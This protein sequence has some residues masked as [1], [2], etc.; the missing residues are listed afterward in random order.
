MQ[1]RLATPDDLEWAAHLMASNEPWITLRRDLEGARKYLSRAGELFIPFDGETRL[2]FLVLH[3]R[4]LAGSPYIASLAVDAPARGR[5]VGAELLRIAEARHPEARHI[6]LLV[7]S[8]NPRARQLYERHG[9]R[10]V[11]ELPDYVVAGHS[12]LIMHKRLR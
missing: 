10:Q 12:E 3:E 2:G 5:G 1:I 6:F 11:G 9:Y 7:S 4:G 8:F